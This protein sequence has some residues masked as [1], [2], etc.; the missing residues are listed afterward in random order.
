M[1]FR[2]HRGQLTDSLLTQIEV[3]DEEELI[4]DIN[5]NLGAE[6]GRIENLDFKYTG[7]DERIGWNTYNV[8]I[9]CENVPYSFVIG[10][11][12]G[13]FTKQNNQKK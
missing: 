11:S 12:D 8:I 9:K 5:N 6:F 1:K 4:A 13:I 3:N 2:Y 10:M 7:Y